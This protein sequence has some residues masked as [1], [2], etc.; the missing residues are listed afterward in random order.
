MAFSFF[1]YTPVSENFGDA[2]HCIVLV[3]K[4]CS[5]ECVC[6]YNRYISKK[7]Q[8]QHRVERLG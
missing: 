7:Q 1:D 6:W 2:P 4:V 3:Y 5:C 8:Q